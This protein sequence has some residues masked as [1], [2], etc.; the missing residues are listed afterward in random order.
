MFD[1]LRDL[2]PDDFFEDQEIEKVQKTPQKTKKVLR[3]RS[4]IYIDIVRTRVEKRI[5]KLLNDDP[6]QA[7][8]AEFIQR[9]S[10]QVSLDVDDVNEL[11]KTV[12]FVRAFVR[13]SDNH[14][15][16]IRV[17][18]YLVNLIRNIQLKHD[19]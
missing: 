12:H 13:D 1:N 5:E 14:E 3:F 15:Y 8:L 17:P 11:R 10:S 6:L 4:P 19:E 9:E 7:R 18:K 2:D 16:S